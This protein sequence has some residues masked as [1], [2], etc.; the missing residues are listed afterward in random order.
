[1]PPNKQS[2]P[3]LMAEVARAKANRPIHDFEVPD[4]VRDE[5]APEMSDSI[6]DVTAIAMRVLTPQEER[7]AIKRAGA[8]LGQIVYELNVASL[9]EVKVEGEPV[10]VVAGNPTEA[11]R[12]LHRMHPKIRD[13]VTQAYNDIHRPKEEQ[14]KGFLASRKVRLGG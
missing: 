8:D 1:M 7:M 13:L 14:T 9:A 12:R 10:H 3:Q 4:D 5:I 2:G 6:D 11:Q